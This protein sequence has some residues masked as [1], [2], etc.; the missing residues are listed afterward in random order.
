MAHLD[1]LVRALLGLRD[2]E[3]PEEEIRNLLERLRAVIRDIVKSER[4]LRS[5]L[6]KAVRDVERPYLLDQGKLYEAMVR[7]LLERVD[8]RLSK[9]D[10]QHLACMFVAIACEHLCWHGNYR[11]DHRFKG[12]TRLHLVEDEGELQ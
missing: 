6:T 1:L 10:A 5:V 3:P 12:E 7:F 8:L 9:L 11:L 2:K 4:F